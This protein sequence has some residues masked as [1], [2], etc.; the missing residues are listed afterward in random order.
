M[1]WA[2]IV[3]NVAGWRTGRGREEAEKEVKDHVVSREVI[4]IVCAL[5]IHLLKHLDAL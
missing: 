2:M 1:P 4:D 5:K 3:E